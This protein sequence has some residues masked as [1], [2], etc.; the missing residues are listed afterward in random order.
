MKWV[1]VFQCMI[2]ID[3]Q[4]IRLTFFRKYRV[5]PSVPLVFYYINISIFL[6]QLVFFLPV[7]N[8]IH[9]RDSNA[10]VTK[11]RATP[12]IHIYLLWISLGL[13]LESIITDRLYLYRKHALLSTKNH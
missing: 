4:Q 7:S 12:R 6:I 13:L 3:D 11:F 1:F 9:P 2:F 8:I 10:L 5:F